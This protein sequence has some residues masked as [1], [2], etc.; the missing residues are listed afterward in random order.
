[1][2]KKGNFATELDT[3]SATVENEVGRVITLLRDEPPASGDGH[4]TAQ[5]SATPIFHGRPTD[6]MASV[7]ASASTPPRVRSRRS[8][9]ISSDP[10]RDDQAILENVTTRLTR[11]TNELLTEAALRQKLAKQQPDTRQDIIEEA[12]RSWLAKCGYVRT[13]R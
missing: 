6:E 3:I 7:T 5:A 11:A 9:R 12:L 4:R 8:A 1:M 2:G 13:S 10:A